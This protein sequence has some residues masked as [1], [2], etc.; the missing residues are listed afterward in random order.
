MSYYK[1]GYGYNVM[2]TFHG[3]GQDNAIF[4]KHIESLSDHFTIY[5]I[6]LFFHGKSRWPEP[7]TPMS[8][9]FWLGFMKAFIAKHRLF[10]ISLMGY[11]LG[12]KFV[13][14]TVEAVP[15][16]IIAVYM[17]APDG[18]RTNFWYGL[19]TSRAFMRNLF[20]SLIRNPRLFEILASTAIRFNL[21][22]K[23]LTRFAQTQMDTE[24]KRKRVYY[25]WTVFRHLKFDLE[26]ISFLLNVREINITIVIGQYDK[27]ITL[28][29]TRGLL[30]KLNDY[31]LEILQT[32]HNG[33][34]DESLSIWNKI[35]W[36]E[37]TKSS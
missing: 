13:L 29:D 2:I 19:A 12:G 26:K 1:A 16:R 35:K 5:S 33:M 34:I 23:S 15:E 10:F 27:V 28:R 31:K 9:E 7:E 20:K 11:S 18:I 37:A 22:D 32:G 30:R 8:K 24:E 21:L 6:D 17:I 3:F 36:K 4:D 14:A 25:C